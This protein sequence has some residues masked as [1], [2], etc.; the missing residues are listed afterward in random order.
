MR[1]NVYYLH[2]LIAEMGRAEARKLLR[3]E[4]RN[5]KKELDLLDRALIEI[6]ACIPD[7]PDFNLLYRAAFERQMWP[8][9][10]PA[11]RPLFADL[12]N[13]LD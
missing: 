3:E 13:N 4:G 5:A 9:G 11:D 6:G 10:N 8:D 1:R 2:T 7:M 12:F